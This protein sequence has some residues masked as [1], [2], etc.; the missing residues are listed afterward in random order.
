MRSVSTLALLFVCPLS[1][2]ADGPEL[3][4]PVFAAEQPLITSGSLESEGR[5]LQAIGRILA[6]RAALGQKQRVLNQE[7]VE[8]TRAV[9]LR[10]KNHLSAE[11]FLHAQNQL[12]A[13]R[14]DVE[15]LTAQVEEQH[16]IAELWKLR[17]I[18]DGT[19]IDFRLP[20]AETLLVSY[21]AA[22]KGLRGVEKRATTDIEF[23]STLETMYRTLSV[24]RHVSA[25]EAEQVL[26]TLQEKK[27][28]LEAVQFDIK[29][30]QDAVSHLEHTMK[31][32]RDEEGGVAA[33]FESMTA[34]RSKASP[35]KSDTRT[36]LHRVRPTQAAT[37]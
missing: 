19:D 15:I 24:G 1:V 29:F 6:V 13:A 17:L 14:F 22:L 3:P 5:Q 33:A 8:F 11:D 25:E 30:M 20:I 9:T 32:L 36:V 27:Q 26:L 35:R 2:L 4:E 21:R 7:L 12:D 16:A 23:W 18:E 34:P 28:I 37:R 31:R 10:R